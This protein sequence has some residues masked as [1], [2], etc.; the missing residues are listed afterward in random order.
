MV[1]DIDALCGIP[2]ALLEPC[3]YTIQ[4]Q[5]GTLFSINVKKLR[6]IVVSKY[7]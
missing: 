2:V 4:T 5:I 3:V 6:W 1:N 7:E